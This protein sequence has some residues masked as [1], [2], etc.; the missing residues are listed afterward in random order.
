MHMLRT[1][2]NLVR[3]AEKCHVKTTWIAPFRQITERGV[4]IATNDSFIR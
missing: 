3:E 1:Q 2:E 4:V